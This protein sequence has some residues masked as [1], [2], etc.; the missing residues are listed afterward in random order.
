[1]LIL[2]RRAGQTVTIGEGVTVTVL[3]VKG[4]RTRLG[5]N[6]PRD[7]AVEREEAR[8]GV[9]HGIVK[10]ADPARRED[11]PGSATAN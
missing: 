6:A 4:G 11:Q 7:V 2:S 8:H 1:M 3:E 9:R 5:I 10:T